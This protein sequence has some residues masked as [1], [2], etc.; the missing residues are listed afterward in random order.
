MGSVKRLGLLHKLGN[1]DAISMVGSVIAPLVHSRYVPY[2]HIMMFVVTHRCNSRCQMCGLW[3]EKGT[4]SLSLAQ[5]E[6]I[7]GGN[8]WS[9]VRSLTLTGG[10]PVLRSDLP[11]I[12]E[13]SLAAMP[14]VEHLL[15]AT[16]GLSTRRTIECVTH[17]LEML[18]SGPNGVR[19]FDVQVSLD[20]IGEVHDATRC[21]AGAFDRVAE[22]LAELERL[23][24]RFPRLNRRLSCVL[25]PQNIAHVDALDAFAR[26]QGVR[27]HYSP[28]VLSGE[29]Y[30]NL[31][32][33]QELAF[34]GGDDRA[35]A[36]QFFDRL[37]R[38]DETSLRFYYRDMAR[39]V[40]GAPR[41]RRCMMG[42]YG[43]V[44]EHDGCVYPCVNCERRAF[45][46]LLDDPF[47]EVWFGPQ[48]EEARRQLGACCSTC[49]SM[50]YTQP[51]NAVELAQ[52][53][54]MRLRRRLRS[55]RKAGAR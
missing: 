18:D 35:A 48:A 54:W 43:F 53:T 5:I 34:S 15:L 3:K 25:M 30:D 28:V 22:T 24:A 4:D 42:L 51:V 6:Q 14:N 47:E 11:E 37:A 26:R 17:M 55:R 12:L 50:C 1:L 49:T 36:R 23:Q 7:L 41:G 38:E 2:P 27:I 33:A 10:E 52:A 21:V 9:F 8:D 39:M 16:N 19:R 32:Q 29:Y 20:G 31:D 44:L 45:G 40:Q 46:N 13:R